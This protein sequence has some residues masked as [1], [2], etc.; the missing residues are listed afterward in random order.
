MYGGS[1]NNLTTSRFD[2]LTLFAAYLDQRRAAGVQILAGEL[3]AGGGDVAAAA[4]ADVR[5]GAGGAQDVLEGKHGLASGPLEG[6]LGHFVVV[7]EVDVG[8]ELFGDGGELAGVLGERVDAA[9]F[10]GG[11]PSGP[12]SMM[13]SSVTSR[14]V[15]SK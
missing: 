14:P 10:A 8:A 4:A 15:F 12:S 9:G 7:D 3:A 2:D 11:A 5:V 13:Y 6:Q 1:C